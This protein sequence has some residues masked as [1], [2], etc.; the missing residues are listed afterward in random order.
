MDCSFPPYLSV[1][2]SRPCLPSNLTHLSCLELLSRRRSGAPKDDSPNAI[3]SSATTPVYDRDFFQGLE[4]EDER[5]L[6][7]FRLAFATLE[8]KP[9]KEAVA[10]FCVVVKKFFA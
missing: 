8:E 7:H 10:K 3:S 2:Y 4:G 1:F 9:M 6:G 5:S